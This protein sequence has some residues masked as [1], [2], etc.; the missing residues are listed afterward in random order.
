VAPLLSADGSWCGKAGGHCCHKSGFKGIEVGDV[1]VAAD[2]AKHLIGQL[3]LEEIL[4]HNGVIRTTSRV[5]R[6][7]FFC[8]MVVLETESSDLISPS[9]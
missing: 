5:E 4:P 7:L 6:V 9:S 1:A 3:D 2:F 8:F